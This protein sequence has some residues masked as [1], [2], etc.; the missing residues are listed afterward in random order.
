MLKRDRKSPKCYQRG[1]AAVE[2]AFILPM[3][4]L[5][6]FMIVELGIMQW[7][8]MTMHYAVREGVRFAVSG[9]DGSASANAR[10]QAMMEKIRD[11][12]MGLYVKVSP[13]IYVNNVLQPG[14][15]IG[16]DIFDGPEETVVLR[17]QCTW[18]VITPAWRLLALFEAE[19]GAPA[20]AQYTFNVAATIRKEAF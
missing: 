12:S 16:S 11:S 10:S 2:A 18:P 9:A 17:L 14:D 15:S 5:V 1:A 7:V 19:S 6:M 20:T 13:V 3:M 4:L 8:N